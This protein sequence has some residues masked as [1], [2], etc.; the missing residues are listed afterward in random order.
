MVLYRGLVYRQVDV[1]NADVA[2][3]GMTKGLIPVR[4]DSD[5][6]GILKVR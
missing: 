1:G 3:N 4:V 2:V 5:S 6:S